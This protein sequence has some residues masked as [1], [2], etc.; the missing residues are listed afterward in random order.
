MRG[1]EAPAVGA[2]VGA[3]LLWGATFVILRDAVPRIPPAQLV[4]ARF[5][6]ATACLF[7]W[8]ARR[9]G[10]DRAALVGGVVS[11]LLGACGY[12]FQAIGLATTSAGNSAFLTCAG[13][14]FAGFFAWPLLGERPS[15]TLV[16]GIAVALVGA[17]LLSLRGGLRVGPGDAWTMLGALA[18]ALQVVAVARWAPASDAVALLTVQVAT[19]TLVELPFAGGVVATF[20]SLA[21]ADWARFAYLAVA[22]SL[23]APLL[24]VT[25]QRFLPAGRVGLLFALEP[26]FAL[27]FALA[28]GGERFAARWWIG[29]GLIL[30]AVTVVERRAIRAERETRRTA[31][32]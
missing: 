27:G 14:L 30:L 22:G 29:A 20:A 4:F 7:P 23:L 32:A 10:L 24:W 17:G 3:T 26:V 16:S 5:G 28:F 2:M 31:T 18:F 12:L 9:G 25:A 19:I 8:A 6:V 21:A 15:A 1:R 11:G 13:T